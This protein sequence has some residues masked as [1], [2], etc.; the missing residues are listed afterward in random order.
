MICICRGKGLG[1]EE[2]GRVRPIQV[3]QKQN[4]KGIGYGSEGAFAPWWDDLYNKT[5]IGAKIEK[6]KDNDRKRQEEKKKSGKSAG[7]RK[8]SKKSEKIEK[9]RD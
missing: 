9:K 4:V 8:D 3:D 5:A 6:S 7:K 1:K 2:D